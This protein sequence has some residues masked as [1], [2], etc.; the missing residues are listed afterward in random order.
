M[1]RETKRTGVFTRRALL[2]AGAQVGALGFLAAKLYQV[3]VVEGA[4]YATLAETNRVSARLIAPPRGRLLDRFGTVVAGNKLNWRALLIAE[5]TEDVGGTLDAF[6]PH[7]AAG[8]P[9][10]RPHRARAAPPPPLHP[11]DGARVPDLG[12]HGAHRGQRARPARHPGRCRHDAAVSVRRRARPCRRLRGAAQRG[13][14]GRGHR[15]WRCPAS[16]SAAP[17]WR[18]STTCSLRGRAGAVQL[19]VNAVGR[20][21]RELDRQEGTHGPGHH[22]DHRHRAAAAGAGAPRRRERQRRGDGLPQ[23]RGAGDGH[24][25]VLRPERVQLRRHRRRNG[26]NGPTTAARR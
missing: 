10:A 7:R 22:A 16:A 6:Q 21:I 12:G 19:E 13:G 2:V 14:H 25:P 18:S 15:C 9:R 5:Q 24:Q 17:A 11:G 1:K 4:R 26:W 3:Q 8:R 23:R 20:V